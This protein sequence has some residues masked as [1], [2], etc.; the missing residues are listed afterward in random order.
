MVLFNFKKKESKKVF[1]VSEDV[2]ASIPSEYPEEVKEIH[3]EFFTSSDTLLKEAYKIINKGESIEVKKGARLS[4][5][6]FSNTA[7]AQDSAET[8]KE[9]VRTEK[10]MQSALYYKSKYPL[11][12]F[13]T[14]DEVRRICEKYGLACASVERFRGFVPEKNLLEIER[15]KGV[16]DVDAVK[17]VYS[18]G[19][20]SKYIG[21]KLNDDGESAGR[22]NNLYKSEEIE[23]PLRICAPRKD[24]DLT[25]LETE[26]GYFFE[27]KKDI[28]DPVVIKDVKGGF[29]I[30][31]AWGPEASDPL[32]VNE[33]NN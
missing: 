33:I 15:F 30:I 21:E 2:I 11:N 3:R 6:G 1:K 20:H 22:Y 27:T 5:L 8:M 23:K 10:E 19:I 32:V 16:E 26:D 12:K 28:P 9:V 25:N 17:T 18:I 14:T 4:A 7:Q 24:M 29:L 13:I 31:T